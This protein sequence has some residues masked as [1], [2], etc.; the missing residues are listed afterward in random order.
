MPRKASRIK[1]Y[2]I[3]FSCEQSVSNKQKCESWNKF[4]DM[5]QNY[6]SNVA[7]V[8]NCSYTVALIGGLRPAGFGSL[9]NFNYFF[10][11]FFCEENSSAGHFCLINTLF[12]RKIF[13]INEMSLSYKWCKCLQFINFKVE[14]GLFRDC[15]RWL[16]WDK[17][18]WHCS[19]N[20]LPTG[21]ALIGC[22]NRHTDDSDWST[23][24]A[25]L[26]CTE[27][28]TALPL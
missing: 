21:C 9:K 18:I 7:Q 25:V 13:N 27:G 20:V 26:N 6:F 17:W 11:S 22:S 28:K 1:E 8:N 5:Y 23:W 14:S 2:F 24:Q 3:V 10:P 16:G 19:V 4:T 15:V 12:W